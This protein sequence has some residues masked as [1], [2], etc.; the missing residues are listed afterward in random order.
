MLFAYTKKY[1][2]LAPGGGVLGHEA[3][4]S[5]FQLLVKAFGLPIGLGMKAGGETERGPKEGA[6]RLPDL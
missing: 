1:Q 6:E 3:S 2:V 4:E 5:S